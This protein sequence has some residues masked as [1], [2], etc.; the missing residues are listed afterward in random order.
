MSPQACCIRCI[1][2]TFGCFN[3]LRN[4]LILIDFS[5]QPVKFGGR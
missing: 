5:G 3:Y 2:S 4:H 1:Y